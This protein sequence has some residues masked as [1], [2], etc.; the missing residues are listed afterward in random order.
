MRQAQREAL[1][2]R[3]P[4]SIISKG[5]DFTGLVMVTPR[6][7][8]VDLWSSYKCDQS[9]HPFHLG[10]KE[11]TTW[12]PPLQSLRKKTNPNSC[13][14]TNLQGLLAIE[15]GHS[16]TSASRVS[17]CVFAI[18]FPI[19]ADCGIGLGTP[20]PTQNAPKVRHCCCADTSST[21]EHGKGLTRHLTGRY[22][23]VINI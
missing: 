19:Q 8:S 11:P 18:L 20:G 13:L 2:D 15:S 9:E 21:F 23:L 22:N 1:L 16:I 7:T 17:S 3:L 6:V 10:L 4:S 5:H 14:N 12:R